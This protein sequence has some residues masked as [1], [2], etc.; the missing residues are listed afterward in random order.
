[1]GKTKIMALIVLIAAFII[2]GA[3]TVKFLQK[4]IDQPQ[5]S[6]ITN[7]DECAKAGYPIQETYPERCVVPTGQVFVREIK[8][9]APVILNQVVSLLY[10]NDSLGFEIWYPQ[11]TE[12][13]KEN[14]EGYLSLTQNGLVGFFL[15]R[16]LFTGTNLGE[17]AVIIGTSTDEKIVSRCQQVNITNDE[18]DLG[19][20]IIANQNFKK[21]SAT[22]VG[23]GNIYESIIYRIVKNNV[24]WEIVELLHS[25]NI[26]NYPE[27]T[28]VEFNKPYFLGILENW[29]KT[30][31][32]LNN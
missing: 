16:E 3:L 21:F 27:D 29:V 13:R 4:K 1:M 30:F 20:Q 28:V 7:F 10:Q 5:L 25:G 19:E 2:L 23:A 6:V 9:Q 15:P 22:G 14:L 11:G 32:W 8:T 17:A 18:K 12:I 24:C 31:A 26:Y